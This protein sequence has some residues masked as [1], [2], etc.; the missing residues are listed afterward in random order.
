M[1][2]TTVPVYLVT[3]TQNGKLYLQYLFLYAYNVPYDVKNLLSIFTDQKKALDIAN[4]HEMDLEHMTLEFDPTTKKLLRL[5]YGS[6]GGTE[7]FWL[8]PNNPDIQWNGHH[9]IAYVARGGHGIYPKKG[10][11]VR[12]L[13]MANDETGEGMHWDT[14]WNL[15][16]INTNDRAQV[17]QAYMFLSTPRGHGLNGVG[18]IAAQFSGSARG[19]I[20]RRY[21]KA[22]FCPR[23]DGSAASDVA[24]KLCLKGKA[25]LATPPDHFGPD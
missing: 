4:M 15:T 22:L 9:P 23:S 24:E 5:Y 13:G 10:T 11:Y 6:H 14:W 17:N 25:A 1:G 21:D 7:G 18:G 20:G 19:D 12:V 3:F 2:H 16:R 8:T